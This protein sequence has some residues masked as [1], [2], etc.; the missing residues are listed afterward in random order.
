MGDVLATTTDT[1]YLDLTDPTAWPGSPFWLI[2]ESAVIAR[3]AA[4]GGDL[5]AHIAVHLE[6]R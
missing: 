1:R 2:A 4:A 5:P 6:D 3:L